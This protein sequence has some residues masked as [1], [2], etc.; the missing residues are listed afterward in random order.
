MNRHEDFPGTGA[1]Q[2]KKWIEKDTQL[3]KELHVNFMR[4]AHY[5]HDPRWLDACD[6]S[7]V[8]I[9]HE[10]PL[11][12]A[13]QSL[14]SYQAVRGDELYKNAARQLIETIERD[15]NHPSV[16]MWSVGNE[17]QTYMPSMKNLHKRLMDTAKRFDPERPVTFAVFTVPPL[18]PHIELSA[19]IADV[20][21]IN[22]YYGWY[23]EEAQGIGPYLEEVHQ[24]WPEKPVIISE[25]GGGAI[26]GRAPGREQKIG[27]KMQGFTEEYQLELYRTQFEHILKKDFVTGT[28]PWILAD[29]RDDKRKENPVKDF[30]LKGL[31][32]YEREK[33]KA[34]RFVADTYKQIGSSRESVGE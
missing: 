5:P 31:V 28:M 6:K 4:P 11:Y 22:E 23:Y 8:M 3:L 10:I 9:A 24:K 18:S 32:T 15:R 16:V 14:K 21:F 29:F 7:G 20:L 30:N 19:E 33:K 17:N 1:V 25:F 34:F 26:P 2:A 13:P 27:S 12:Q